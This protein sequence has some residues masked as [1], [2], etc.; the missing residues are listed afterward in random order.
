MFGCCPHIS[1]GAT[2]ARF[3]ELLDVDRE[4]R[5]RCVAAPQAPPPALFRMEICPSVP[6][7]QFREA[8]EPGIL[9]LVAYP[10]LGFIS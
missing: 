7:I 8:V 6:E 4:A 10:I 5:L 2:L 9:S 3:S 1:A